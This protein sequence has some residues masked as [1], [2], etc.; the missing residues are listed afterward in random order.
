MFL[1]K[2]HRAIRSSMR[3]VYQSAGV[4]VHRFSYD[5]VLALQY[6]QGSSGRS[7]AFVPLHYTE[8][9]ELLYD[10]ARVSPTS[11][12]GAAR[13]FSFTSINLRT[14]DSRYGG[15][16]NHAGNQISKFLTAT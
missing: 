2:N 11:V 15:S 12:D 10:A 4:I 3:W 1:S 14:P 8:A 6:Q 9:G 7:M 5:D 13:N 16:I